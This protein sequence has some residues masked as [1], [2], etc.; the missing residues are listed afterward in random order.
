MASDKAEGKAWPDLGGPAGI[1]NTVQVGTRQH[2]VFR[3]IETN[4]NGEK[5]SNDG[6]EA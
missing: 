4:S 1:P 6:G 2:A 3:S 5:E